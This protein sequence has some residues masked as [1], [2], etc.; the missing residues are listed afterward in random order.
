MTFY[1]SSI[2]N[3]FSPNT[4]LSL[5]PLSENF[6]LAGSMIFPLH[7]PLFFLVIPWSPL[8]SPIT[9]F[10]VLDLVGQLD[11]P[12]PFP[13]PFFS[14]QCSLKVF[15]PFPPLGYL[16]IIRSEGLTP[17]RAFS[18]NFHGAVF[19]PARRSIFG[20]LHFFFFLAI[21]LLRFSSLPL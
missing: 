17:L 18:I 15:P 16:P 8:P 14:L 4:P 6:R 11:T 21:V 10:L 5:P 13:R 12:D 20:D 3:G 2:P 7:P 9:P 1:G 19:P